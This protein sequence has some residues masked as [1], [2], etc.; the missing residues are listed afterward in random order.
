MKTTG[1][2]FQSGPA[3]PPDFAAL[4]Q[5]LKHMGGE[6]VTVTD[7]YAQGVDQR[8]AAK[9]DSAAAHM[10]VITGDLNQG[11][12]QLNDVKRKYGAS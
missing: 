5:T 12:Q 11:L 8:S 2:Q 3:P 7:E 6:M 9:L 1:Q 4:D 10:Q